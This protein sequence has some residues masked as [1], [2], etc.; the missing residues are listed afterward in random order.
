MLVFACSPTRMST[1]APRPQDASSTDAAAS[2]FTL[3]M[4]EDAHAP[5]RGAP[6]ERIGWLQGHMPDIVDP[7]DPKDPET[8]FTKTRR[9]RHDGWTPEKMARFLERFAETGI[10]VEACEAA[11]M[12]ARAAYNLRDRDTLFAAGWDAASVKARTLLADEVYSR[13]RNGVVERIYKDGV[14]VA[15][16][17]KYD[18]RLTMAVLAR[19]DSRIDRAETQGA[20]HLKVAARWDDYLE[21]VEEDRREDGLAMLAPEP[22]PEPEPETEPEP[23]S[24][25][26]QTAE[27]RELHEL[28]GDEEEDDMAGDDE[29]SE[30]KHLV[31]ETADGWRTDYPPPENFEGNEQG[32]YGDHK[33]ERE[34][35]PRELARIQADAAAER[36]L[37]EA[38]R[39]AWF[40]F[41]DDGIDDEEDPDAAD[42]TC[43]EDEAHGNGEPDERRSP[44]NVPG[45]GAASAGA[46]PNSPL[47]DPARS[48][49]ASP[50]SE[51]DSAPAEARSTP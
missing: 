28:Q 5:T 11:G 12:S 23:D 27:Q 40:G 15:E 2:P 51:T 31:W 37:A 39:D 35:S 46:A 1:Q 14:I 6:P 17:H 9:L 29:E 7:L 38:Q 25:A 44:A 22:E 26:A 10:V 41:D 36:A 20:A 24:S 19:L 50:P 8:P 48:A 47:P 42:P 45:N 34:L 43:S 30:D 32:E 4:P 16:R 49:A 18:N 33:Y 21:A 3:S 13:A